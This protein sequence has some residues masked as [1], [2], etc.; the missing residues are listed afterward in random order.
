MNASGI[1]GSNYNYIPESYKAALRLRG[2]DVGD[3]RPPSLP[4]DGEA[5]EALKSAVGPYGPWFAPID[6]QEIAVLRQL[7]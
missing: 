5:A 6:L 4:I 7:G 3:C 2:L 1:I